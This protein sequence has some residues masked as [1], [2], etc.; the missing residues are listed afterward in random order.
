M[1]RP[2]AA[3]RRW[4]HPLVKVLMA[5][6][7]AGQSDASTDKTTATPTSLQGLQSQPWAK[8]FET[9]IQAAYTATIPQGSAINITA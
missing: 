1:K 6:M 4:L 2:T 8:G 3:D 9:Q 5:A 7:K